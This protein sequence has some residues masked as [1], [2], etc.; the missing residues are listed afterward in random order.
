M[1][2]LPKWGDLLFALVTPYFSSEANGTPWSGHGD[3]AFWFSR[4]AWSL[5]VVAQWRQHLTARPEVVVWLPDFFCNAPL[6]PLRRIGAKL[7]FYPVT[8]AMVPDMIACM[9]LAHEQSPD[10][11]VLVHYF[12]Y[13]TP[14]D[15][16]VAFCRQWHVLLVE[17]ATHVLRPIP[18]VGDTGDCIM[19]S[20]YKHLPVPDGAVLVVRSEG[21]SR[22][23]A[24]EGA[25]NMLREI[26]SEVYAMPGFS[27]QPALLW[28]IKRVLQR[29]GF[30]SHPSRAVFGVESVVPSTEFAHPKMSLLARRLL[31]RLK[32]CLDEAA[33]LRGQRGLDWERMLSWVNPAISATA[34]LRNGVTPYLAGFQ[35]EMAAS[36]ETDFQRWH[37]AGLPV[38]TWPDLAP[39]VVANAE[40]HRIA[41]G[42]RHRRLYL[43]VHQ[44]LNQQQIAACGKR[45]LDIDTKSWQARDLTE[46]EWD[47]HWKKC[48]GTNLL[49][50]WQYGAA[51]KAA[52]GWRAY[53]WLISDEIGRPVAVVQLL[54]REVPIFGGVA[55]LN[56]GPLL[57]DGFSGNDELRTKLAA[58]QVI[59]REARRNRWR[60][61]QAAPELPATDAAQLGLAALGLKKLSQEAWGSGRLALDVDEQTLLMGLKGKWRNCLRKGE[62]LG[63]TISHRVCKGEELDLL[64]RD[65]AQLQDSKGFAGLS[66][67]LIRRLAS[68]DGIGW[69]VALFIAREAEAA[70]VAEHLGVLMTIRHGDTATYVIG[71]ANDKGRKMQAN[72]VLLWRAI[73]HA[74]QSGCA[75][76]DIGGLDATT[77]RGIAEFK[78]GLNAVPYAL[79]GEWR[80]AFP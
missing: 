37:R 18:G 66:K 63:V 52:A 36:A 80:I 53:R 2:P 67:N 8:D 13:P 9:E 27:Y 6:A 10:I 79:I 48:S 44:S 47:G 1:A 50:S 58:L 20:P 61:L 31:S 35:C 12:G 42:L 24:Q 40:F 25:L 38:T 26:C 39:E 62:K 16:V 21:P 68:Q 4:S 78:Q 71:S 73:L 33:C 43:P 57:L 17:D 49:Q 15:A 23:G 74:K 11:F 7:V 69:E 55:R 22:L 41:L 77:P 65:Y 51:K 28:L 75:W 5:R 60:V 72:S 59:L 70:Q 30:R 56:R 32:Q 64:L 19:Y 46:D 34:P 45:L 29:I 76:F 54:A 3:T 14:T